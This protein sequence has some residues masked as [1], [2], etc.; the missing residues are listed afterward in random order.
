MNL[1]LNNREITTIHGP[2]G[3]G[4]T[5]TLVAAL[6][7]EYYKGAKVLACAPSNNAAD[8]LAEKFI[9]AR[10]STDEVTRVAHPSRV[11]KSLQHVTLNE[12]VSTRLEER[13]DTMIKSL[14][15]DTK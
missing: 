2:P 11:R 6:M 5:T 4:K 10:L 7:Q 13:L 14:W 8:N 15:E 9:E 1:A 12:K 3:T